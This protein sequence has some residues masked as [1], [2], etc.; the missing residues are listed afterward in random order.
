M[1][2][3]VDVSDEL[4]DIIGLWGMSWNLKRCGSRLKRSGI[5]FT[6]IIA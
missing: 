4:A 5:G 1:D 2:F 3:S 6:K